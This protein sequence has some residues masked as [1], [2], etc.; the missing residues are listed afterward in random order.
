V[1]TSAEEASVPGEG[2]VSIHGQAR[3]LD[4]E[5]IPDVRLR[6]VSGDGREDP[7]EVVTA[8][9]GTFVLDG[10]ATGPWRVLARAVGYLPLRISANLRDPIEVRLHLVRQPA[11]YQPSPLDLMPPELPIPPDGLDPR[12]VV[13]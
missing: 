13:P 7:W 1:A 4:G 3:D 9:D 10:I 6:L 5:L 12:G 2:R 8:D 11:G